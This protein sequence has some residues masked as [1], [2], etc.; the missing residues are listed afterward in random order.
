MNKYKIRILIFIL[1]II[2]NIF[3]INYIFAWETTFSSKSTNY[4]IKPFLTIPF[5]LSNLNGKNTQYTITEWWIY[6]QFEKNMHGQSLHYWIDFAA[7]YGTPVFAPFDGYIHTSYHNI[8]LW[9]KWKRRLYGWSTLNY[10]LWYF[11]Q[12]VYQDPDY[13]TDPSKVLFVQFAHL[14]W[15]WPNMPKLSLKDYQYDPNER[16]IK[17]NN[18]QISYKELEEL[19]SQ[20]KYKS[21]KRIFVKKWAL[22]GFVWTSWIEK[23]LEIWKWFIPDDKRYDSWDEGH[24]HFSIYRRDSKWYKILSSSI[25]PYNI[26]SWYQSYPDQNNNISL[27]DSSLFL[28]DENNKPIF[29][30]K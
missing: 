7:P 5:S 9:K 11:I 2:I 20:T 14:K 28:K 26:Y 1:I 8:T 4:W 25:D 6:S 21:K 27:N 29:A 17:T 24:I 12:M 3:S 23:G 16:A 15:F 19:F 13:P 18:H 30:K 22:I 10:W